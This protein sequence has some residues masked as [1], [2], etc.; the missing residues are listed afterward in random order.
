MSVP[1]LDQIKLALRIDADEFD[2]QITQHA[3]AAVA[4]FKTIGVNIDPDDCPKPVAQAIILFV[5]YFFD[6]A[7]DAPVEGGPSG[8]IR[9]PWAI[10]QLVAPYKE[11]SL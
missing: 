6:Y 3:D 5:K 9:L 1:D 4:Y 8:Q 10:Y 11:V 7:A 2:D